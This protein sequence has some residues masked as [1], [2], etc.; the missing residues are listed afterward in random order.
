[1]VWV[2]RL[3]LLRQSGTERTGT[4]TSYLITETATHAETDL[5]AEL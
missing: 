2:L 3:S 5:I 4:L 1:M